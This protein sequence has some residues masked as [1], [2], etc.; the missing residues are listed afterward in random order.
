MSLLRHSSL[1]SDLLAVK[2]R[3]KGSVCGYL[4]A[5]LRV[6]PIKSAPRH[7]KH[8]HTDTNTHDTFQIIPPLFF[9]LTCGWLKVSGVAELPFTFL[10]SIPGHDLLRRDIMYVF[11][12]LFVCN[13]VLVCVKE[14]MLEFAVGCT[15][16][17]SL[18][19][20]TSKLPRVID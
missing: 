15:C 20:A 11:V 18:L 1:C 17:S 7:D 5:I 6:L 19:T 16:I 8:K 9:S 4:A 12:C 13:F 2:L 14:M 10:C 3:G